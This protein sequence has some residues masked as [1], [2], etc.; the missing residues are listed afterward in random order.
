M[1]LPPGAD[2]ADEGLSVERS[3]AVRRA[4]G[5]FQERVLAGDL[6]ADEA[7]AEIVSVVGEFGLQ[8][9][10]PPPLP[11]KIGID[12]L[13]VVCWMAVLPPG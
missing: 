6:S 8:P 10:E 2:L 11:E 13:G 7:A 3:S 9:V 4:L 12:D 5:G 1:A